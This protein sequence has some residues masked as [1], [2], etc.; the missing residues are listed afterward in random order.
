MIEESRNCRQIP[1]CREPIFNSIDV[2]VADDLHLLLDKDVGFFISLNSDGKNSRAECPRRALPCL[3]DRYYPDTSLA[4]ETLS[5]PSGCGAR[6]GL[7]YDFPPQRRA[8]WG[9][10]HLW[11]LGVLFFG[12]ANFSYRW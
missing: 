11:H 8:P 9:L 1:A 3:P 4:E 7:V 10:R 2:A 12:F 6:G 5:H